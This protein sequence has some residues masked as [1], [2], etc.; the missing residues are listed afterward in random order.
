MSGNSANQIQ[1]PT[2]R[3]DKRSICGRVAHEGVVGDL[4]SASCVSDSG[5]YSGAS[6]SDPPNN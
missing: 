6:F 3:V 4:I 5:T 2:H 1:S